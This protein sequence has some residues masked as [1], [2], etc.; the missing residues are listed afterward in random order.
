M[1]YADALR[2]LYALEPRGARLGLARVKRALAARGEPQR[3]M[4]F[5]HIAG[6]NGKGSVAV[7]IESALRASGYRTGLY[8]SPHLHRFT[9]RIRVSGRE[10][11]KREVARLTGELARTAPWLTFFETA[12]V[13]ALEAFRDARCD[14]AVLEVGLGG[15]LDATNVVVPEACAIT[16]IGADHMDRL[17]PTLASIAREKAGILKRRVPAVVGARDRAAREAIAARARAVRAPIWWLDDDVRVERGGT[18]EGTVDIVTPRARV[19]RVRAPLAGVH[20]IDNLAI[21]VATLVTLRGRRGL[22]VDDAAI[23]RGVRSARWP[24]RL[25]MIDGAPPVL[26]D[27]AHNIE[28]CAALAAHVRAMARP[29]N[30]AR[31]VL[32]FGAMADKDHAG[33]LAALDGAFEERVYVAPKT[34][35]AATPAALAA[36]RAGRQADDVGAALDLAR[37]I[38]T[39]GGLVVVAGSIFLAGEAR[40]Q[41]L[42]VRSEP[43]LPL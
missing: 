20:Q 29:S 32:V 17:G 27:A 23:R 12:T 38:A 40:A 9:E 19:G 14:V 10:V 4:R 43:A 36:V 39:S 42:G 18:G 33:M 21:A 25:E 34:R 5:V 37:S 11:A 35:R 30:G 26:V 15:R 24:A 13:M 16:S 28:G 8:T 6:T 2:Y 1:R 7:M 31:R 41:L 22:E 3:G